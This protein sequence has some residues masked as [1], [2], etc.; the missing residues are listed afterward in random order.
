[1]PPTHVQLRFR[2]TLIGRQG[3]H[4]AECNLGIMYKYGFGVPQDDQKAFDYFK[5]SAQKNLG[6]SQYFL[7]QMYN[8]GNSVVQQNTQESDRYRKLA[9]ANSFTDVDYQLEL[10]DWGL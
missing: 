6:C 10:K 7:S 1:M 2:M 9:A 8:L 5:L 4:E 3:G